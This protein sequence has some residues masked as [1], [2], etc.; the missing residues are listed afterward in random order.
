MHALHRV[1]GREP[2]LPAGHIT[3]AALDPVNFTTPRQIRLEGGRLL[4]SGD[5]KY[6]QLGVVDAD[7]QAP[8]TVD[9]PCAVT[10]GEPIRL[11]YDRTPTFTAVVT[12]TGRYFVTGLVRLDIDGTARPDSNGYYMRPDFRAVALPAPVQQ[13]TEEDGNLLLLETGAV[14]VYGDN[15][16]NQLGLGLHPRR[17]NR[18]QLL[19]VPRTPLIVGGDVVLPP[20]VPVVMVA[21]TNHASFLL[22]RAG[23]VYLAGERR[24]YAPCTPGDMAWSYGCHT[25]ITLHA[26]A[27]RRFQYVYAGG[28]GLA[29]V[30]TAGELYGRNIV[31]LGQQELVTSQLRHIPTPGP[32]VELLMGWDYML[33]RCAD[34]RRYGT[35]MQ[36]LGLLSI[37]LSRREERVWWPVPMEPE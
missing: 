36:V 14:W 1:A 4:V 23:T 11:L 18:P 31:Y 2:L 35:G 25:P 6:G 19:S 15:D 13:A 16:L 5:N 7:G 20:S 3:P 9:P 32:V 34:G 37:P 17:C 26:P 33:I 12:E 30:D 24:Q 29:L 8:S 27:G 22:D 21:A 10:V 28:A